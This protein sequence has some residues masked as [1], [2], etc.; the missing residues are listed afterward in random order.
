MAPEI[1]A[2]SDAMAPKARRASRPKVKCAASPLATCA[3]EAV[4]IAS[5]AGRDVTIAKDG[6]SNATRRDHNVIDVSSRGGSA[7]GIQHTDDRVT[8]LR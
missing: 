4:L 8:N 3:I 6:E 5:S 1:H 7:R 2:G